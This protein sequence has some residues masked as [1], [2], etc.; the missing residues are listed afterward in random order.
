MSFLIWAKDALFPI[1]K[2]E[3][4]FF[5]LMVAIIFAVLYN[6]TVLRNMKDTLV[7]NAAGAVLLPF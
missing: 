3:I 2:E 6:Y 5:F 1:K 7:I 4:N